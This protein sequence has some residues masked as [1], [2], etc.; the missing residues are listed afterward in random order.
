[1]KE[2]TL[3]ADSPIRWKSTVRSGLMH[4]ILCDAKYLRRARQSEDAPGRTGA[5]R[6]GIAAIH[7][8]P[9]WLQRIRHSGEPGIGIGDWTESAESGIG[10]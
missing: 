6:T 10:D 2:N 7:R 1:M 8:K 4:C 5:V 9:N 3:A